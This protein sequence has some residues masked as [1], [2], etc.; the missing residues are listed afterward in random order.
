MS[1]SPWKWLTGR[2]R[3]LAVLSFLAAAPASAVGTGATT[4]APGI[5]V[6]PLAAG[7]VAE[8]VVSDLVG[9]IENFLALDSG[10]PIRLLVGDAVNAIEKGNQVIVTFPDVRLVIDGGA[11]AAL[12][13][14]II[15]VA[16]RDG[17]YYD[18]AMS[19]PPRVEISGG[20]ANQSSIVVLIG[21][22]RLTG[23]W[24]A[25]V[26]T[27]A[28]A[29]Y[30]IRDLRVGEK[31]GPSLLTLDS[32]MGTQDFTRGTPAVWSGPFDFALS[33]IHMGIPE[34]P[35]RP[36]EAGGA[37][38]LAE[39]RYT[40][41]IAG[42]DVGAWQRIARETR[43]LVLG[44]PL[45]P[46]E[47]ARLTELFSTLPWGRID[48]DISLSGLSV[49]EGDHTLFSLDRAGQRFNWDDTRKPGRMGFGMEVRGLDVRQ[50]DVSPEL[51]PRRAGFDI[52]VD[53]FP[54]RAVFAAVLPEILA[55]AP[56]RARREEAFPVITEAVSAMILEARPRV[57]LD[58]MVFES[59]LLQV[60][61]VGT[62]DPD[63]EATQGFVGTM[64]ATV[65]GLERAMHSLSERAKIDPEAAK[66]VPMLAMAR[67]FGEARPGGEGE[68]IVLGYKIEMGRDGRLTING[69]PL[70]APPPPDAMP[71]QRQALEE[72][73]QKGVTLYREG[74]HDDAA[75]VL[76]EALALGEREFAPGDPA[77][78]MLLDQL[79]MVYRAQGRYGDAE[80]PMK[81][82]LAIRRQVFGP[83]HPD[84]A[85]SFKNL[86]ELNV[87]G[88]NA[89]DAGAQYRLGT[90]YGAGQGVPRDLGQAAAWLG[91]SAE[92]GHV[93][94]QYALAEMHRLGQGIGRD[95]KQAAHWYGLA[96]EQGHVVAQSSLGY[97]YRKGWGVARDPV[98]A[99]G[100]YRK[101]AEQGFAQAQYALG[102]M[103][104]QG[105][106]TLKD[107]TAA[108]DWYERA[109]GQNHANAQNALAFMYRKGLGVAR[110]DA[111]A[112]KWYQA[113]AEQGHAR[114]QSGLGYLLEYG[115]GIP[116]DLAEAERWY[117]KAARQGDSYSKKALERLKGEQPKAKP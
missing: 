14:V 111:M 64:D 92:Q 75:P 82:A 4:P 86:V 91:R 38:D 41:S 101:S 108:V 114:A 30:V 83:N 53:R 69:A 56:D 22:S 76:E 85:K 21:E 77:L 97:L 100:W 25:D 24:S 7:S 46:E 78:A 19:L 1:V 32:A 95:W 72:T 39:L 106:G 70:D 13:D 3:V 17:G 37:I 81:R 90:L 104:R 11:E 87:A 63:P 57:I 45:P 112:A 10:V 107:M 117:E 74:R 8:R 49:R 20:D 54:V 50:G 98:A 58:E 6:A 34:N 48:V 66:M 113:A 80:P 109:A 9:G 44:A 29:D 35:P 5:P 110:D 40:G 88:A 94:A 65:I 73:F 43:G 26:Q 62:M 115:K 84:V 47:I 51:I 96:A 27:F 102:D 52:T 15:A 68:A 28:V 79:A 67:G 55:M 99:V 23:L 59:D 18:V 71:G 12:G 61:A 2:A 116:K 31:G 33:G 89:G 42:F 105:E 103:L 93:H 60:K 36:A 16:P